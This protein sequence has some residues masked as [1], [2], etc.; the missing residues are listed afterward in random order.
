MSESG[1]A[2]R[3]PV[4]LLGH[5][6]ML[7]RA[8]RRQL[9]EAE[10]ACHSPD[11]SE[12]DFTVA[13]TVDAAFATRFG[14][15]INC[16]AWTD[17]DQAEAHEPEAYVLNAT[18]PAMLADQCARSGALLVHYSTDYVFNGRSSWPYAVDA[19]I[20]PVN[21]YGR[22]KAAGEKL[23]ADSGCRHLIIRTS[24]LYAPWGRNFVRTMARL[25]HE[26]PALRV[27]DDQTT[28]VTSAEYLA[29][30]SAK[31]TAAG[32]AGTYHVAGGETCTWCE[33]AQAIAQLVDSG[34]QIE[35]CTTAEYPTPAM[36]PVYS[37][38]DLSK[39][40]SIIGAAT[41]WRVQLEDV[42]GRLE[43]DG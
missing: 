19:P 3:P 29:A 1:D 28:R 30:A 31:L 39:A 11:L 42:A 7:W 40:E 12:L 14:T 36:R 9:D 16:A 17:V 22:T 13:R 26:R 18:G 32:A 37:V 5:G 4:L 24:G 23:I 6:G 8:W 38:L 27:V 21:A 25:M 43:T 15:V 35:P 20:E 10:V 34:C 33:F 2:I 41:D